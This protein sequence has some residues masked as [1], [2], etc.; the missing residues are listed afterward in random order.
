MIALAIAAVAAVSLTSAQDAFDRGDYAQAEALA[1]TGEPDGPALY[2]AALAR[3]RAGNPQG[4]LELLA[5]SAESANPPD[6]ALWH[7][8]RASC[9]YEL[10][11]FAEAEDEYLRAAEDPP[12]SVAA[13]VDAAFAA[14]DAGS[15]PRARQL[16][17]EVRAKAAGDE[18]TL[19]LVADLDAHVAA[20]EHEKS[21]AVY[22][23]GLSAYDAGDY[24]SARE[25]FL[26]AVKLDP[27]D[28][29]SRIMAAASAFRLGDRGAARV[30]FDRAL[31]LRLDD[32]DAQTARAYLDLLA[33]TSTW[34]G[35]ARLAMGYDS[36]P[37]QTGML[38]PNEFPT[39]PSTVGPSA[40]SS[41]EVA[42]AWRAT[43]RDGG[44]AF[45]ADY[46]FAQL[47][48][49]DMGAA[50]RSLQQHTLGFAVQSPFADRLRG[51]FSL[52][53][54]MDFTGLGHFR[55]L[56]SAVK[57]GAF[58]SLEET[59]HTSTRL[60]VAVSRKQG[61]SAEFSYLSGTRADTAITQ[62]L[63]LGPLTL[64]GGYAFRLEDIGNDLVP[65]A[66]CPFNGCGG[67]VE[68]FG[69]RGQ[70]FWGSMRAQPHPRISLEILGGV[71]LRS[72]LGP[73]WTM[74]RGSG[75]GQQRKDQLV[76][77][78]A[79]ATLRATSKVALSVRYDLVDN[80]SNFRTVPGAGLGTPDRSYTKQVL[81]LGTLFWW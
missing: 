57:L 29:R 69:Y 48:Y 37:Q 7:F 21:L 42:L 13:M 53:G 55:L 31:T 1:L 80:N 11:R 45:G 40:L 4:A 41:S 19:D 32:A 24:R 35:T 51:G 74:D 52:G 15:I 25:R 18:R 73:D 20:K 49:L 66:T 12:L 70:T 39:T 27:T 30:E 78:S 26:R 8:N 75:S 72:Y 54:E 58:L 79:S 28:G 62:D 9:L 2:L 47:A 36:N 23:D 65:T 10:G 71:E 3:F 46:G 34:E 44:V 17:A 5:R 16:A 68:A 14:L 76:F 77:G 38:Q 64:A 59:A 61:G 63:A 6:P 50:D 33:K 43:P 60:D 81:S 56:Q 67:L 22:E